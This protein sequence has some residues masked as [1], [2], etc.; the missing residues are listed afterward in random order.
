M[1][2]ENSKVRVGRVAGKVWGRVTRAQLER[3]G[4]TSST[5]AM[6]RR[7]GYLHPRLP[8]VYA[9]GHAATSIEAELAEALLYAGPG[10][11]LS[12]ATAA[13]W[14]GLIDKPPSTIHISTP[15]RCR[16]LRGIT[17][18]QRR[19]CTRT[20]HKNLPVTIVAQ[21]LLDFASR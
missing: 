14:W 18:H 2:T 21:T 15:R 16:S 8:R 9:V 11:M 13:W 10:A 19:D 12:H 20:W 7:Q 6:W 1:S 3:L 4:I 17:V 5:I